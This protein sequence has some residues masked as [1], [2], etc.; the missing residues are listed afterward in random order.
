MTAIRRYAKLKPNVM[1]INRA[2]TKLRDN[3]DSATR[4]DETVEDARWPNGW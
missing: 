1:P 2:S 3:F 4:V